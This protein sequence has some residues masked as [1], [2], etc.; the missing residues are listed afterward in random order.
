MSKRF[1]P[2]DPFALRVG[3]VR[4]IF[5]PDYVAPDGYPGYVELPAGLN[6]MQRDSF[7]SFEAGPD[8]G[9]ELEVVESAVASPGGVRAVKSRAKPKVKKVPK[10]PVE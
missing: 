10:A 5:N 2:R 7:Y 6:R 3:G 9:V 4:Y 1:L 8:D